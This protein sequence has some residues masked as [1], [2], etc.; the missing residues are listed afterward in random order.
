MEM[1]K[2]FEITGEA[3]AMIAAVDEKWGIGR[4]GEIP[5][6]N[7]EDR[8]FF[9]IQTMGSAVVMGRRTYEGLRVKPLAGR[10]CGVLSKDEHAAWRCGEVLVDRSLERLCLWGRS[11]SREVYVAG[12]ASV[13]RMMM[14]RARDIFLT[15]IPGGYGCDVFFPWEAMLRGYVHVEDRAWHGLCIGHWILRQGATEAGGA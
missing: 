2:V 14:G 6:D 3:P 10:F 5:W 9:K 4:G 8:Q 12:G 1:Q 15:R 7:P 13:Y 11:R